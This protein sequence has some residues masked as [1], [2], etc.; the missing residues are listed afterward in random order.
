MTPYGSLVSKSLL[1]VMSKTDMAISFPETEDGLIWDMLGQLGQL[2]KSE[3]RNQILPGFSKPWVYM[4]GISQSSIYIRTWAKFFHDRYRTPEEEPVYDGYLAIVGPSL[5]RINQCS[6]DIPFADP[7]QKLDPLDAPFISLSSESEMWQ[8]RYTH[9]PDTFT[10]KGGIVTYEVAGASH[11]R[12]D[13]PG[14][15]PGPITRPSPEHMRKA[16]VTPPSELPADDND[17]IW[18]PLIRGAFHNLELWA[19]DGVRPPQV[20]G[21]EIAENREVKRDSYGNALGGVRM[22]YIEAPTATH[23]GYTS[24]GGMGGI[25]GTK[26]PFS[27]EMLKK[28]YPDHAAY[29]AK[30]FAATDRLVS[31]RWISEEDAI[32]MKKDASSARIP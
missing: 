30:F 29:V 21:I 23:T 17:F 7:A 9:Q 10:A 27:P 20:P 6:A 22:P 16:G 15:A 24:T 5:A 19:R 12:H 2:L 28:L 3:Q 13:V 25:G 1:W 26:K 18:T 14:L 32:A 31:G 11:R 8:A 4:T